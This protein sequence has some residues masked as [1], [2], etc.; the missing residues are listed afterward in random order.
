[1]FKE[2]ALLVIVAGIGV[3]HLAH[4]IESLAIGAGLLVRGVGGFRGGEQMGRFLKLV[5]GN[6][7]ILIIDNGY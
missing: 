6:N 5:G 2:A 3:G 4:C 1:M 7:I